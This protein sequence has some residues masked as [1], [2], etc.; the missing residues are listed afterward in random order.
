M[1]QEMLSCQLSE[2]KFG[3][4]SMQYGY[5]ESGVGRMLEW[6]ESYEEMAQ[7]G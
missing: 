3:A 2:P 6:K 7:C 1:D 4:E 5:G